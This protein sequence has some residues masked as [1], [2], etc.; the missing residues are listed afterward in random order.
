MFKTTICQE[1]RFNKYNSYLQLKNLIYLLAF[2]ATVSCSRKQQSA[3]LYIPVDEQIAIRK[4]TRTQTGVP[5]PKY[6]QNH[7]DYSIKAT[8][9]PGLYLVKGRETIHYFNDS[10][11]NLKR[12]VVN[13]FRMYI[14]KEM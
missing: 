1:Y 3:S 10:P 2:F 12:L 5:G 11:E 7:S 9:D 4:G 13:I 14:G 8:L 6:F